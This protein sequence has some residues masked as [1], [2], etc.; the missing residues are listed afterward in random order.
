MTW[1]YSRLTSFES[2]PYGWFL[3]YLYKDENGLPLKRESGFFAEF[4]SFMHLIH[5]LYLQRILQAGEL[6]MFYI[7]H[8]ASNVRSRPP[9][10]KV[11]TSYFSQGLSY[12]D[13]FSFP[14]RKIIGV[15]DNISF[16]FAGKPW[17]GFVDLISEEDGKLIITDHKSRDLKPRSNRQKPTKQDQE[18]DE[19]LRQLYVYAAAAKERYGNYPDILEFNCFRS[20]VMIREPFRF[21]VLQDVEAWAADQIEK[22][23]TNQEWKAT[24]DFWRCNHLCDVCNACECKFRR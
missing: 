2:C 19:Y 3:S 10:T 24:P 4:G 9:S 1:S 15:E 5:Q 13:S 16:T 17:T 6:S 18:L 22:I 14:S 12:F 21:E 20:K 7:Q 8:F 11:Y 23:T